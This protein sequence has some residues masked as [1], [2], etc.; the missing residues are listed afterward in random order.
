MKN[1]TIAIDV[2]GTLINE[3]GINYEMISMIRFLYTSMRNVRVIIWS[4]G[5][6]EYAETIARRCG[7]DDCVHG[8]YSKIGFSEKVDI[9]FDDVRDFRL[10]DNNIILK[11]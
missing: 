7:I 2:D 5:G 3:N 6:K 10:A 8:C 11:Q 4:G 9:A 1:I